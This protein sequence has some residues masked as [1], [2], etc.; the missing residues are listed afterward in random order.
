MG[1]KRICLVAVGVML[2]PAASN[3]QSGGSND[4]DDLL[5]PATTQQPATPDAPATTPAKPADSAPPP[6][7]PSPGAAQAAA[8]TATAQPDT[9]VIGP[10]A[11]KRPVS[12][13]RMIE[14]IVVTAQKREESL[15]DIPLSV[16]A[17]SAGKLE[18]LGVGTIED[19]PNITPGLT[20]T[21]VAGYNEAFLRGVGTDAYLPGADPSVPFYTDGIPLLGNQGS[22]DNLGKIDRV[23]VLKGPQGTLFGTNSVG[24]AINVITPEPKQELSGEVQASYGN[25]NARAVSAFANV[26]VTD[27]VAF[28]ISGFASKQSNFFTNV[29]G[30]VIDVWSFGARF[31]LRW[32]I[33]SNISNTFTGFYQQVSGNAGF[34]YD[35]TRVAPVFAA[36]FQPNPYPPSERKLDFNGFLAG[37]VLHNDLF[38]DTLDWKANW[39]ETKLIGSAQRSKDDFVQTT[40]GTGS[41]PYLLAQNFSPANQYTGELQFLS[42]SDTPFADRFTWV[43]GLFYIYGSGGGNPF[44]FVAAPGL[45]SAL[46]NAA[47]GTDGKALA[48]ALTTVFDPI[49]STSGVSLSQGIPIENFGVIAGISTSAY[50]QGTV[51]F[52]DSLNLTLGGRYQHTHKDLEGSHTQVALSNGND[53]VLFQNTVPTLFANQFSPRVA[54]QWLPFDSQSQI[55]ASWARGYKTP[56]YN[57]VNLLGST[58]GPI[59]PV[60]QQKN[61]AYELGVKTELFDQ[62]LRLNSALFYTKEKDL[63]EGFVSVLTGGVVSYDNVP[64]ALIRGAEGDALWVPLPEADPGF[65][66]AASVSYIHAKYTDYPNGRGFDDATGLAFGPGFP[67][68]LLPARNLSGNDI[69]HTPH[70]TY[71]ASISQSLPVGDGTI[72]VAL[73]GNFNSGSFFLPQD[74]DL[75]RCNAFYL[76]NGHVT[77]TYDR[78]HTQVTAFAK[79]ITS[80]TFNQSELVD[81]FGTQVA[82]NDPRTFGLRLKWSF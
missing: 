78:W 32:D 29:A 81:D 56:T 65:V 57:T 26:P 1:N 5:G 4:L 76:L 62:T 34:N 40:F 54:L 75:Y 39:V 80:Q 11:A 10:E 55:Y 77:Y 18:A 82:V 31:K 73:D 79:N 15:Q 44:R 6:A 21:N 68:P 43:G 12:S 24:G 71:N 41:Q 60:K 35:E 2:L 22:S 17:F 23:E 66:L 36:V 19:L 72:E 38:A 74:S 9:L 20:I 64:A 7:P 28:N 48:S 25:Y 67:L 58:F 8:P 37:G 3:A 49:L 52:T 46:G 69:V 47:L 13:S 45:F 59:N 63:L 14:E 53:V 30:P 33:V 16:S 27:S 50:L 70:L 51:K 42:T 61:D